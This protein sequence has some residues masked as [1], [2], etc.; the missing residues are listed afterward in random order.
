MNVTASKTCNLS[1]PAQSGL[2]LPGRVK[3]PAYRQRP[4]GDVNTAMRDLD[5][6][7]EEVLR[8]VEQHSLIGFN[9]ALEKPRRS[10]IR[11][12]TES[13]DHFR[14]TQG[15]AALKIPW[16][17]VFDAIFPRKLWESARDLLTQNG[18]VY[19]RSAPIL[20]AANQFLAP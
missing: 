7:D 14:Q 19:L 3:R 18:E 10:V 8:L 1:S 12:L 6:S 15:Q 2:D 17:E 9:I 4:L 13:I 16:A 20:A 11:I 5:S